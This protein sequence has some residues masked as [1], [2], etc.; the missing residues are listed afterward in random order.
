MF[1]GIRNF[2]ELNEMNTTRRAVDYETYFG[3]M[4]ISEE[5]K[6]KRISLAEKLEDNFLYVLIF[7]FTMQQYSKTV[8]WERAR[9]EFESGYLAA[10]SGVIT[11]DEYMESYVRRFSYD[12]IDSTKTHES[13]P[14]YY[15]RDRAI[16]QSENESN[17]SWEHQ[18]YSDAVKSGK[19]NKQWVTMKD[20]RVR[21]THAAVDGK[22]IG[23]DDIFMVGNSMFR[24]AR[25]D[26]FSPDS[27]DVVGC[28]CT[29]KY[30]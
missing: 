16:F 21:E 17:S 7:L 30:F 10:I 28:R 15:S 6:K 5:E 3:E 11:V 25:D 27:K 19:K 8:D 13:D 24:Y 26:Y 12:V 14:W 20:K 29:T 23:I 1:D 2:D 4:E 22:I 18:N 9:A